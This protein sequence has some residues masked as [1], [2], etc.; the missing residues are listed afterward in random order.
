MKNPAGYR[1]VLISDGSTRMKSLRLSRS[2]IVIIGASGLAMLLAL[3]L[4]FG[5]MLAGHQTRAAMIGVL[6]E[7]QSLQGQLQQMG[8]R[9]QAVGERLGQLEASDDHLRLAADLPA[10]DPDVRRAGV[11][12]VA[13]DPSDYGITDE[14]VRSYMTRLDQIE[15]EARLQKDSYAEIERRLSERQELFAKTPSIRPVAGGYISSNFG[16]R[17]D[18]FNGRRTHHNGM[19]ISIPR[20]TP[21]RVSAD[22]KVVFAQA[23]P[24]LGKLIV[25]D[26]GFGFQTAYGHLSTINVVRGQSVQRDQKIGLSGSSGRSSG[27]HLHYEVHV[28]GKSVDPRDFFYDDAESLAG[29]I[30]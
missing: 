29:L 7:N 16:I 2:R 11:G 25:I 3:V 27:P 26:H 17:R 18:P 8:E 19:D 30:R 9:I 6:A 10:I 22:G 20:G 28:N 21:V 24:G 14:V 4:G 15:R 5:R 12:G 13:L 23:T 1:V